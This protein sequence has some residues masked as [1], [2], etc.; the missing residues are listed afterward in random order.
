VLDELCRQFR[1]DL[2]EDLGCFRR[3]EG[4]DQPGC[5]L[6][7]KLLENVGSVAG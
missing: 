6:L 4:S 1:R 2:F 5:I 3:I 7:S